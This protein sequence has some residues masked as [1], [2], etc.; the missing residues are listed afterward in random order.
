MHLSES[1]SYYFL[2][3]KIR[4][5]ESAQNVEIRVTDRAMAIKM[6]GQLA[7]KYETKLV[8]S[9][10]SG[11]RPKWQVAGTIEGDL[12]VELGANLTKSVSEWADATS[13]SAK[14][15]DAELERL[16]RSVKDLQREIN[17][18]RQDVRETRQ[19]RQNR[20][21]A[22]TRSVAVANQKVVSLRQQVASERSRQLTG[23]KSSL[24]SA[25]RALR[26]LR[27]NKDS[28][29]RAYSKAKRAYEKAK[30]PIDRAKKKAK[31]LA[32]LAKYK[33]SKSKYD[34]A[35]KAYDK[36]KKA[37]DDAAREINRVPVDA[38]P[39][40]VAAKAKLRAASVSLQAAKEAVELAERVPVDATPKVRALIET[41]KGL[42]KQLDRMRQKL[43][44]L[45]DV[46]QRAS[47]LSEWQKKNGAL[48]VIQKVHFDS[49]LT[50]V[51]GAG[52]LKLMVDAKVAGEQKQ[53]VVSIDSSS[54]TRENLV[55][56][57]QRELR[58]KLL[59]T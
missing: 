43:R 17:A 2:R 42:T 34:V 29:Y 12:D 20:L 44:E 47:R 58:E 41:Q 1:D 50:V 57:I 14:R 51:E 25:S 55:Q 18:A 46:A 35:K 10:K 49:A 22:A 13:N 5:F 8:Y 23:F 7:G 9:A 39:R 30:K 24:D 52:K 33:T 48:V 31:M 36:A 4:V 40:I 15:I 53:V 26:P 3:G 11:S 56:L 59:S 6:N 37:Y 28:K 21:A 54:L 45:G 19:R 27:S 32:A 38:D 16:E